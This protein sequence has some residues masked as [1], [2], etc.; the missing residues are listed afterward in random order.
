MQAQDGRGGGTVRM[1][2]SNR[3]QQAQDIAPL[4]GL[5]PG[6]A[7]E[8]E[9]EPQEGPHVASRL[10]P[11]RA[12]ESRWLACNEEQKLKT[13]GSAS[14][15]YHYYYYYYYYYQDYHY[16]Y[17]YCYYYCYCCYWL[18]RSVNARSAFADSIGIYSVSCASHAE[19]TTATG[20]SGCPLFTFL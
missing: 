4:R 13:K 8:P 15:S 3:K 7:S 9:A 5:S 2:R 1:P 16:H 20:D 14:L 17:Y 18:G 10:G 19:N 6:L 12:G 11:V